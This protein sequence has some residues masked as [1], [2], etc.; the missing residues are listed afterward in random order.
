MTSSNAER[1]PEWPTAEHVPAEELARRQGIQPVASVDDLTR[2][3]RFESDE[4]L[5][6]FLADLYTSR[7]AGAA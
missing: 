2:P 1:M 3:G 6:E 4:E 7:R 5:D